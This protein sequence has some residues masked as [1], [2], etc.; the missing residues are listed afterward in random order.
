[1]STNLIDNKVTHAVALGLLVAPLGVSVATNQFMTTTNA[2]AKNT[3]TSTSTSNANNNLGSGGIQIMPT[4]DDGYY[5]YC[6]NAGVA[7][8]PN[9]SQ[10]GPGS[11]VMDIGSNIA[12]LGPTRPGD[13]PLYHFQSTSERDQV[14][15]VQYAIWIALGQG[16][17]AEGFS[18]GTVN[19]KLA[20]ASPS[21]RADVT[22][23]LNQSGHGSVNVNDSLANAANG[24]VQSKMASDKANAQ[25]AVNQEVQNKM[26]AWKTSAQADV[27]NQANGKAAAQYNSLSN[28]A[29]SNAL[30]MV[31]FTQDKTSTSPA[32]K[33]ALPHFEDG[34]KNNHSDSVKY[35][36]HVFDYT[37]SHDPASAIGDSHISN[38]DFGSGA[39]IQFNKKLPKDTVIVANGKTVTTDASKTN[40]YSFPYGK[41]EI[42]VP[43]SDTPAS[44]SANMIGTFTIKGHIQTDVFS[45]SA[46]SAVNA[47]QSGSTNLPYQVYTKFEVLRAGY[48]RTVTTIHEEKQ[49]GGA[50]ASYAVSA[51]AS[52]AVS[53]SASSA[54]DFTHQSSANLKLQWDSLLT[55]F[56]IKKTDEHGVPLRGVTFELV[57]S[58]VANS[59][60][61]KTGPGKYVLAT[62]DGQLISLPKVTTKNGEIRWD[63]LAYGK[64]ELLEIQTNTHHV[65]DSN[66][67]DLTSDRYH[68]DDQLQHVINNR[69]GKISLSQTQD[70]KPTPSIHTMATGE[71]GSK[72]ILG[73]GKQNI[74]DTVT[75]TGLTPGKTYHMVGQF[76]DQATGKKI[77]GLHGE[78]TFKAA[79]KDGQIKVNFSADT[80]KF[81]GKNIVA[82]ETLYSD[83]SGKPSSVVATHAD[84]HDSGQTVR[85]TKP[86]IHTTATVN[87]QKTISPSGEVTV[88]DTV[89]Y[90]GLVP[91]MSMN[92]NGHMVNKD[93]GQSISNV[94]TKDFTPTSENGTV[95]VDIK[96]DASKMGQKGM[97][98]FEELKDNKGQTIATHADINDNGQTINRQ[99]PVVGVGRPGS[100]VP[101]ALVQTAANTAKNNV[102]A[103]AFL[104]SAVLLAGSG[105]AYKKDRSRN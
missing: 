47:T 37:L 55:N 97:V 84:I 40:T 1:M 86:S 102:P 34:A 14:T 63:N 76:M 35:G 74:S 31:H 101:Q 65:I 105:L 50:Q 11:T 9:Y 60:V 7:D 104:A 99:Q 66:P 27:Q 82:F 30:K 39:A 56:V 6:M 18:R 25:N 70:K 80:S 100:P 24:A 69:D 20:K 93:N 8:Q 48:Q 54:G 98:A 88:K 19:S 95:D 87:G 94:S 12:A 75:F 53:A 64:Y 17:H 43:F 23:L 72:L 91:G 58:S 59:D 29:A 77:D 79:D 57:Q 21:V 61:L 96:T 83:N 71:N 67:I 89:Q 49:G 81:A 103:I 16:D 38:V 36:A 28:L 52:A 85:V 46:S 44:D 68:V 3:G 51:S 78:Q 90:E 73:A 41:V 22:G 45:A 62:D 13:T 33:K 2:H 92:M 42:R 4:T 32:D 10:Y 15:A 5:Q 26:Q